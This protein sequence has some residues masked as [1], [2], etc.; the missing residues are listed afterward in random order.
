MIGDHSIL[1]NNVE[2]M[3]G[4]IKPENLCVLG[5]KGRKIEY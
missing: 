2:A 5:A 1:T 3:E 4:H